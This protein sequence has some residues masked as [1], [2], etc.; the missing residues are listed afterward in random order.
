MRGLSEEIAWDEGKGDIENL[1]T[2]FKRVRAE[3]VKLLPKFDDQAWNIT[4][5]TVWGP[6]TLAWVVS[7]TYQHTAE[8]TNSVMQ[9]A[10]IWDMALAWQRANKR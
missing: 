2:E 5:A 3:Q 8:H 4:C 6:V 7:K 1:L 9:M 10:L